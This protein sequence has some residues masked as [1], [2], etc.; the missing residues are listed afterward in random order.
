MREGEEEEFKNAEIQ[1]NA[2]NLE[3]VKSLDGDE[4]QVV[5]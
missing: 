1:L 3:E 4:A 2:L 5:D